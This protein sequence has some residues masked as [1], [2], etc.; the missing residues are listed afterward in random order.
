MGDEYQVVVHD[1]SEYTVIVNTDREHRLDVV[2]LCDQ[3][4]KQ[5]HEVKV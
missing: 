4:H 1:R 3:H 5:A 2:W